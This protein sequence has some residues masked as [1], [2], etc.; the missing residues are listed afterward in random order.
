[1]KRRLAGVT[2][3]LL[4]G[5]AAAGWLGRDHL[6]TRYYTHKLLAATDAAGWVEQAGAWGD[7]VPERLLDCLATDDATACARSGAALARLAD[8]GRAAAV[9]GGLAERF[10]HLSP[11]GRQSALDCARSTAH[12]TER[13][14]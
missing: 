3:L 12:R 6:K 7:A 13:M 8:D 9:A 14:F 5:L 11:P 4:L 2:V 10:A 1:M